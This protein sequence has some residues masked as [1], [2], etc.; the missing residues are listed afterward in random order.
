MDMAI[1]DKAADEMMDMF[2]GMGASAI[3]FIDM[4]TGEHYDEMGMDELYS[5]IEVH[6]P[7]T[8]AGRIDAI[9]DKMSDME[10]GADDGGLSVLLRG[11]G[12]KVGE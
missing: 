7:D 3:S 5:W 1:K 9:M 11:I 4:R 8:N 12:V 2:P 10:S 6:R